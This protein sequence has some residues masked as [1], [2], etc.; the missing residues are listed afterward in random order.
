MLTLCCL[1]HVTCSKGPGF[2]STVDS[3]S[4]E[5]AS[6]THSAHHDAIQ[7]RIV[8]AGSHRHLLYATRHA[9]LRSRSRD[10]EALSLVQVASKVDGEGHLARS[11]GFR[12]VDF[13]V[14]RTWPTLPTQEMRGLVVRAA[15]LSLVFAM[16]VLL[17]SDNRSRT[18]PRR[19]SIFSKMVNMSDASAA[20]RY[21]P[22]CVDGV[23]IL[24][25]L[26]EPCTYLLDNSQLKSSADGVAYRKSQDMNDR[27]MHNMVAYGDSIRGV[28]INGWLR[29]EVKDLEVFDVEVETNGGKLGILINPVSL[30]IVEIKRGAIKSYNRFHPGIACC[31]G[32]R[33][34]AING[35]K[36]NTYDEYLMSLQKARVVKATLERQA[37]SRA[38]SPAQMHHGQQAM[39]PQ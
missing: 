39:T 20:V 9:A 10:E 31:V 30:S 29:V 14:A 4:P 6:G 18:K 25:A 13:E 32:D 11:P 37:G 5:G 38:S 35:V 34:V 12:Q 19:T 21:V 24:S 27:D 26:K 1:F 8:G 36:V 28:L 15:F 16:M 22:E 17:C 33:F 3:D 7:P 2:S 23:R